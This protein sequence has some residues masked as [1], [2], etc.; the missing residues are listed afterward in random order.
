MSTN[1]IF[2][3]HERGLIQ[4]TVHT[5][6]LQCATLTDDRQY[7]RYEANRVSW[8]SVRCVA[9]KSSSGT[10]SVVNRVTCS[11]QRQTNICGLSEA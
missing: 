1:I 7:Y 2:Y 8:R 3:K 10:L 6:A 9:L 4:V 11:G 5:A